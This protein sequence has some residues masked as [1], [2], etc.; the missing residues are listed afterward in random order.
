MASVPIVWKN[1]SEGM[2]SPFAGAFASML[3]CSFLLHSICCSVNP[4][5]CFSR[6]HTADKYCIR[7]GSLAEQSFSICPV[8]ILESVLTMQVVTPRALSF[9][10][11]RMTASYSAMLFVHLFDSSTKLRGATYLY[12]TPE[13]DVMTAATPAPAWHHAPSQ[14]MV[15]TISILWW[16]DAKDPV[17][18]TMKSARTCD[19]IAVPGSNVML[20]PESSVV[21]F[22]I[23]MDASGILN[24]SPRP[25][26]LGILILYASK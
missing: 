15:Q 19:L 13:D 12:L 20:Q 1:T 6:L 8:T 26:L 7:T 23:L 25:R 2:R 22:T 16:L 11:P 5:N 9:R 3:A 18:S 24:R 14:W 21:H 17:Q 10:S 4:L